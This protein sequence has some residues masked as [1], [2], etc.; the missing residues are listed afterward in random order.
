MLVGEITTAAAQA[1]YT[2]GADG[3]VSERLLPSTNSLYAAADKVANDIELR[4]TELPN[5]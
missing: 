5:P 1:A 2:W 4:A 3:L